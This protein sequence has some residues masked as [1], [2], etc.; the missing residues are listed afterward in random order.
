MKNSRER[1]YYILKRGNWITTRNIQKSIIKIS[2]K[3]HIP[4]K[5]RSET[6]LNYT[7]I[8]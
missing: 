6:I 5:L 3:D 1:K 7:I 2:T 8:T 4:D